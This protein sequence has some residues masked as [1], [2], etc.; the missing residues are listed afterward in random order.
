[1]KLRKFQIN[2][3][4]FIFKKLSMDSSASKIYSL[5]D[6]VGLGK[7]LVV[8][9]VMSKIISEETRPLKDIFIFCYTRSP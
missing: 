1:M 4:D 8:A 3:S 9:D 2:T 7:T 6:Q 5:A